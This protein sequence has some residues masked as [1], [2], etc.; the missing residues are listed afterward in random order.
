MSLFKNT[1]ARG[2]TIY[3]RIRNNRKLERWLK[4]NCIASTG[5]YPNITGMRQ[6]YWGRACLIVRAGSYAYNM[7]ADRGQIIPY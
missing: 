7:G 3:A 1:K 2:R 6:K 5:P 4:G